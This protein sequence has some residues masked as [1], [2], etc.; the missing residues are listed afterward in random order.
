MKSQ[1]LRTIG[2]I[3]LGNMGGRMAKNL[4]NAGYPLIGYDI[5][6]AKCTALAATGATAGKDTTEVVKNSDVIM[7]SLRSSDI[8]C[9]VA[10]Q[11]LIPNARDDHVF[12]DLGT[13]EVEKTRDIAAAF[14]EKGATL[15][16]APV[17]GGTHGSETGTLRIFVGG[18]AASAE[19]C[20]PILEILGEPKHVVY[21]GPSGSGQIV[22]GVNQ[23]AMGLADAAFM[24]A[25]AF[26]VC[27]GVNPIAIREAVGMGDGWRGQ[28]DRIAKRIIDG[29][30]KNL[31][32]K[33]PELPYFLAAAEASGFE[34]PL[35]ETLYKFCKKANYEMFDN[36]NRPSR[37]FWRTLIK[38]SDRE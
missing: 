7:T 2:F 11:Y 32:V 34:I 37:S 3:G 26:G 14:T 30:G 27:A 4:H 24:E 16:D 15:I 22:K 10:E 21:C 28:F 19:K 23:L 35:T 6:A 33:Y 8:F 18:D 17:S 31:V 13:T 36:M 5:D 20:R 12:I 29:E 25:M 1:Q 38:D 9:S